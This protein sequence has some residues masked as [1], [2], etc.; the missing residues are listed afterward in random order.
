V[1]SS[2]INE[3]MLKTQLLLWIIHKLW[4]NMIFFTK[5]KNLTWA[6]FST[7]SQ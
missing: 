4:T 6:I 1:Y 3:F 5:I 2:S 7:P